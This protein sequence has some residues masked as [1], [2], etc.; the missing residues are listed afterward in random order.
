MTPEEISNSLV[1]GEVGEPNWG[2]Y[3]EKNC[4][5]IYLYRP[6]R[7]DQAQNQHL[8]L[9]TASRIAYPR[10]EISKVLQTEMPEALPEA[11]ASVSENVSIHT[12][13][14][15]GKEIGISVTIE[16]HS[17]EDYHDLHVT[18]LVP[19]YTELV[20][21][22]DAGHTK[23]VVEGR[24]L[25]WVLDVPAGGSVILNY[26]VRCE[27]TPGSEIVIPEGRVDFIPT[28]EIILQVGKNELTMAQK[29]TLA[30]MAVLKKVPKEIA[31]VGK[32]DLNFANLF[33]EKVLGMDIGLP[34][35][36]NEFLSKLFTAKS[37]RYG[38]DTMLMLLDDG[39]RDAALYSM[40]VRNQIG[41]MYYSVGPYT[42]LDYENTRIIDIQEGYFTQGDIIVS[43]GGDSKTEMLSEKDLFIDIYLGA[44]QVLRYSQ[45]AMGILPYEKTLEMI[46][47]QNFVVVL[48]PTLTK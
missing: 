2:L 23:P 10:M 11:L 44:G 25:N 46:L 45:G 19:G 35:T 3:T 5:K 22:D 47:G 16:N 32:Q 14:Y 33:Y 27:A 8:P 31:T 12:A 17:N 7:L 39:S 37:S 36:T 43:L 24:T 29:Q 20:S 15:Q 4:K 30:E 1:T 41:G 26:K 13:T 42:G 40:I 9:A 6:T 48:R 34:K 28:R 38:N 18:E 21:A